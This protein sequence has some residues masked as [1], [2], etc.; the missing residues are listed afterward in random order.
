MRAPQRL[1]WG[2]AGILALV[3]ACV[4]GPSMLSTVGDGDPVHAALLRPGTRVT[5]L[6]LADGRTLVSPE[7][8]EE[9]GEYLV[10]GRRRTTVIPA[11]DVVSMHDARLWLGSDR[12]GRDVL[13]RLLRGGRISRF[14]C[15]GGC[16]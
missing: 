2:F 6:N 13:P 9:N 7:V 11:P 5:V 16:W 10:H 8:E 4:I 15:A 3:V 1:L 14:T 12:F